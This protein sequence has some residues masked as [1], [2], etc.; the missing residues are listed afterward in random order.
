MSNIIYL[1][2]HHVLCLRFYRGE[3]YSSTF[4]EGMAAIARSLSCGEAIV[5]ITSGVDDI[6]KNCPRACDGVCLDEEKSARYDKLTARIADLKQ[7]DTFTWADL[8]A[9]LNKTVFTG[10]QFSSICR[11]CTWAYICHSI[12]KP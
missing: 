11:D 9:R 5:R 6:C 7:N 10:D 1:R 8:Q 4:S 12:Q 2:P 3:G